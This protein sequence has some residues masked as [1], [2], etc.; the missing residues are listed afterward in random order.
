[1]IFDRTMML[2][3]TLRKDIPTRSRML[4]WASVIFAWI[5]RLKYLAKKMHAISEI[6]AIPMIAKMT[7][8]CQPN[9]PAGSL[10]AANSVANIQG[11]LGWTAP[12]QV[13]PSEK[14][15]RWQTWLEERSGPR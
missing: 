2:G 6:P 1:M 9:G 11:P 3:F 5:Q 14:R 10:A 15:G 4:T 12:G 7:Y 8:V 13:G